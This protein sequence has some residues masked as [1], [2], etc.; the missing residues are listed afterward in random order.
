MMSSQQSSR[1]EVTSKQ[2]IMTKTNAQLNIIFKRS[3][4]WHPTYIEQSAWLEHIPFAF[5]LVETLRPGKIVELGTHYGSSYFSFCQAVTKLDLETQ[6][7]AV[8]TWLGDEHAGKYGEEVYK[9]VSKYNQQHYSSFSTLIRSTFDQA[10][11][12]F[13]HSSIDLLHI[14][15]LHT[16]EAVRHDFESWLPKLSERA[17]I[18]MHDTNVRDR[19]FGVFQLMDELKKKYPHFEFA[20]GHG[21]GV[22]GVGSKQPTEMLSF[23]KITEDARATK[24]VH[25]I[26]SRLG[27]ACE[28]IWENVQLKRQLSVKK[29]ELIAGHEQLNAQTLLIQDAQT[30]V[31]A[32][33]NKIVSLMQQLEDIGQTKNQLQ[34]AYESLET[35]FNS[36][37]ITRD[38]L[39]QDNASLL[40]QI[41]DASLAQQNFLSQLSEQDSS[42][43]LINKRHSELTIVLE[44][45]EIDFA[46]LEQTHISLVD[47]HNN[48]QNLLSSMSAGLDEKTKLLSK[49]ETDKQLWQEQ[50]KLLTTN[51]NKHLSEIAKLNE[52]VKEQAATINKQKAVLDAHYVMVEQ[53]NHQIDTLQQQRLIEEEFHS[54]QLSEL[55]QSLSERFSEIATLTQLSEE[56]AQYNAANDAEK[57]KIL[58]IQADLEQQLVLEKGLHQ[59]A[60]HE[61]ISLKEEK[62]HELNL[63]N[64]KLSD[65]FNEIAILTRKLDELEQALANVTLEKQLIS[66]EYLARQN[67]WKIEKKHLSQ[68]QS[69]LQLELVSFEQKATQQQL[70][71]EKR[72]S[73]L[74]EHNKVLETNIAERFRELATITKHMEVL[75][76]DL[77]HKDQQ[78][79]QAKERAQNLKKTVSWKLTAPVRAIGRT[80]KDGTNATP[81]AMSA[82]ESIAQ[83]GLF[84]EDWYMQRYPEIAKSGLSA[85]DHFLK[86]GANKGY[87][88]SE[89]F[90]TRWYLQTYPDVAQGSINPLLHYIMHGRAEQ[91]HCQ[92][93]KDNKES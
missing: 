82:A 63:L 69:K 18:I 80:F 51:N 14:D 79:L 62:N 88:P 16:L 60:Q 25:E 26:F 37:C 11:E 90:D 48:L 83:S 75:S 10:L 21:L 6:C 28:E 42:L 50:E 19:G 29:E 78:L 65:R 92:P 58:V 47:E 43:A 70:R 93:I 36:L 3:I 89:S 23:Y 45:K 64:T 52:I 27:K 71:F 22:I 54:Q 1:L 39:Q 86:Y 20:H 5:W 67:E 59:Q 72:I 85:I 12:H 77:Q 84:N 9:Q 4:F 38:G 41:K 17:V 61:L 81:K 73:D 68:E 87:S 8:D 35:R 13:S 7:F 46:N 66:E 24:Q 91:R 34:R 40:E 33:Q 56:Q 49:Y 76:R 15:G 44:K 32:E 55:H 57:L 74:V 31:L 53:A 2:N 30:L